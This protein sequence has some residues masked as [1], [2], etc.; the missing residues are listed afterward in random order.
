MS[1]WRFWR[2]R[3]VPSGSPAKQVFGT[4][5]ISRLPV[6]QNVGTYIAPPP[7]PEWVA[8]QIAQAMRD[9]LD[10]PVWGDLPT[11]FDEDEQMRD[12]R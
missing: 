8:K 4:I 5:R 2:R 1:G 12:E 11:P 6:E 10:R 9:D 7:M 3:R